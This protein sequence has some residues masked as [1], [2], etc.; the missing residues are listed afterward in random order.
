[1]KRITTLFLAIFM[2]IALVGCQGAKA[3]S[4][5]DGTGEGT[6]ENSI[7]DNIEDNMSESENDETDNPDT[8][9]DGNSLVIYYSWS[10]NTKAVAEALAEYTKSDIYAIQTVNA[11]PEDGHE[12]AVI[13]QEER[14]SGNLPA[15]VETDLPDLTQYDVVYIG[16]P[17]W[18]SYIP[19]PLEKYFTLADFTHIVVYPFSTSMGS[20]KTGFLSDFTDHIQNPKK[21]MEYNDFEFPGNYSPDAYEAE[22]LN[23]Q[24]KSWLD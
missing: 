11:Y 22:E 24:I 7:S 16:A 18:N 14:K 19:T 2:V 9:T 13:S 1:M 17:I 3:P 6:T 15:I 5:E 4:E 10:G 21:I 20:G 8:S 12:T 23:E